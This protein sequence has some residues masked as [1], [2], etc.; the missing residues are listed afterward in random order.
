MQSSD[1]GR[2]FRS[3]GWHEWA[4]VLNRSLPGR[5]C[6]ESAAD[7]MARVVHDVAARG[8]QTPKGGHRRAGLGAEPHA[9]RCAAEDGLQQRE[10]ARLWRRVGGGS[11]AAA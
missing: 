6:Q 3:L 1:L 10:L 2:V 5:H 8:Q 4:P 11:C 9:R 7:A